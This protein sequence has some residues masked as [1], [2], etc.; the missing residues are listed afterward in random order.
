MYLYMY[1][2]TYVYILIYIYT[3]FNSNSN[4]HTCTYVHI[5][6]KMMST[7]VC[8]EKGKY[9]Q[10]Q[11]SEFSCRYTCKSFRKLWCDSQQQVL[12]YTCIYVYL[13][14][15]TYTCIWICRKFATRGIREEEVASCRQQLVLRGEEIQQKHEEI[16][17]QNEE[18]QL[19]KTHLRTHV[20]NAKVSLQELDGMKKVRV[21]VRACVCACVSVFLCLS[22]CLSVCVVCD[23]TRCNTHCNTHRSAA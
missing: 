14:T 12:T 18:I 13:R 2:H 7:H 9:V 1:Q 21:Y 17:Q 10:I 6:G 3:N 4:I 11:L 15:C 16:R 20:D 23:L 8:E 22:V 5:H 19:L